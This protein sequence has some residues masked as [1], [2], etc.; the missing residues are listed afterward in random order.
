M[1]I[2]P[3]EDVPDAVCPSCGTVGRVHKDTRLVRV[4]GKLG[5][6]IVLLCRKPVRICF[7]CSEVFENTQDGDWRAEAYAAMKKMEEGT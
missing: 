7:R 5:N 3:L 6:K 1:R 2:I 4:T